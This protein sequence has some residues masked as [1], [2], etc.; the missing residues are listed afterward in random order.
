[1]RLMSEVDI[2]PSLKTDTNL[3]I[4][5]SNTHNFYNK[6]VYKEEQKRSEDKLEDVNQ[7]WFELEQTKKVSYYQQDDIS[8]LKIENNK[9]KREILGLKEQTHG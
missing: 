3:L 7:L 4:N 5:Q 8:N 1:M 9:L 2:K 6:I